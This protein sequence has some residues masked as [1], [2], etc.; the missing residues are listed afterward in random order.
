MQQPSSS[1]TTPTQ[2]NQT[3]NQKTLSYSNILKTEMYPSKHHAIVIQKMENIDFTDHILA[4]KNIIDLK[5]ITDAY[6]MSFGRIC[7]YLK[8]KE[9]ADEITDL[10][11][12]IIIKGQQV[13]IR[14]LMAPTKR[15]IISV[16]PNIP[17]DLILKQLTIHKIKITS[18]ITRIKLTNPELIHINSGRRQVYYLPQPENL[19][20]ESFTIEHEDETH[21]IHLTTEK[22]EKCNRH[23]HTKDRCRNTQGNPAEPKTNQTP[24]PET[25]K[26]TDYTSTLTQNN[27]DTNQTAVT[28]I[29]TEIINEI[30][31]SKINTL[32]TNLKEIEKS[33][34]NKTQI[35]KRLRSTLSNSSTQDSENETITITA[36]Q[37]PH[38][39]IERSI[40]L[41]KVS[42]PQESHT[43]TNQPASSKKDNKKT[44]TE[45]LTTIDFIQIFKEPMAL[46]PEKYILKFEQFQKF[47]LDMQGTTTPKKINQII[48]SLNIRPE[49]IIE[50]IDALYYIPENNPNA[51]S[52]LTRLKKKITSSPNQ[53]SDN[54][55]DSSSTS[56]EDVISTQNE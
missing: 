46:E 24:T 25:T 27:T 13:P 34:P 30:C 28:S 19:I 38:L 32:N 37:T 43:V 51:K 26:P 2:N 45:K 56:E 15:L 9:L 40:T 29:Q 18:P 12:H 20:P 22:C 3:L 14:K 33:V 17:N 41:E 11:K 35:L 52:A 36:S 53:K 1:T 54:D 31:A 6:P 23:G 49:H 42:S 44:K 10:H 55:A 47:V 48:K 5:Q 4:L 21:R 50:M 39:E 7:I 16:P 8:T